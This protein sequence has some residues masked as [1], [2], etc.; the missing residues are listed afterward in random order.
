MPRCP[1][2]TVQS[3]PGVQLCPTACKRQERSSLQKG[4]REQ[5]PSRAVEFSGHV[6]GEKPSEGQLEAVH[7]VH[8][9]PRLADPLLPK[10]NLITSLHRFTSR[11]GRSGRSGS[12]GTSARTP[13]PPSRPPCSS[14]RY[15]HRLTPTYQL[16]G[17]R[18]EA[19]PRGPRPLLGGA[20]RKIRDRTDR[21]LRLYLKEPGRPPPQPPPARRHRRLPAPLQARGAGS[22]QGAAARWRA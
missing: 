13:P 10:G 1:S 4:G 12:A 19:Q 7:L 15:P 17:R 11:R 6:Q 14:R 5:D 9:V 2:L 20:E 3:C 21:P 22:G 8:W 18:R 16:P